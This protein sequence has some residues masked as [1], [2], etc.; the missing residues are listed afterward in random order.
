MTKY[1]ASYLMLF[2]GFVPLLTKADGLNDLKRAL[3]K[4]NSNTPISATLITTSYHQQGEGKNKIVKS[5]EAQVYLSDDHQ[6]LQITYSNQILAKL[7]HEASE[8]IK[9]EN[10]ETPTLNAINKN[11][12]TEIK[13]TLSAASDIIRTM[14]QANFINEEAITINGEELRQL[15]FELPVSAIINDKR[16]REYVKKFESSY[17]VVIDDNGIPIS[18]KIDF[19]G[20][21]RA[22]IVLSVKAKGF[23]HATYQV[24][25]QRLVRITNESSSTFDSTFGYTER[26]NKNLLTL[27]EN[28]N[29]VI[30]LNKAQ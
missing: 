5:G 9:D 8:R 22:Y 3:Q 21:G 26:K 1:F 15:N 11:N 25:E 23:E 30:A 29:A 16:T 4:L 2:F 10:A 12:A 6:G 28:K 17:S 24:V 18:T 20:K 19:N 14:A 13:S 27:N 7:E